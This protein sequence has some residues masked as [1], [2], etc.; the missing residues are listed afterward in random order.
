MDLFDRFLSASRSNESRIRELQQ[1]LDRE[2]RNRR[3]LV[4]GQ[5]DRL[6]VLTEENDRLRLWLVA[7]TEV[8]VA[9]GL[10]AS[11]DLRDAVERLKPPPL[12]P[13]EESPFAG[14]GN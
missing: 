7:L 9:K 13:E 14:L 11:Q 3:I 10:L 5:D 4:Q 1:T 2:R 12:P 8:L 6:A